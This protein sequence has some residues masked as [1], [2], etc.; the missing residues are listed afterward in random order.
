MN[1]VTPETTSLQTEL[2]G[3][4]PS[5]LGSESVVA[6]PLVSIVIAN[7]NYAHFLGDAIA[8]ALQQTYEHTEVIVVDD[9]STDNSKEV[10]ANYGSRVLPVLIAKNCGQSSSFNVGFARSRGQIICFLDSD[11]VFAPETVA[12]IVDAH[13][14]MRDGWCF[15]RLQWV[16]TQMRPVA[17]SPLAPLK[18]GPYDFRR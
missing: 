5:S 12:R 2:S 13:R 14:A 1:Q 4:D 16:D 3:P 8:S 10:I 15:H 11:D 9:G 17:S 7:Y 18:T 6:E